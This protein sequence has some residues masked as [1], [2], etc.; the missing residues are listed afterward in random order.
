[1]CKPDEVF[2]AILADVVV[3]AVTVF[4]LVL[5]GVLCYRIIT[6]TRKRPAR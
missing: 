2:G 6:R 1:M 5:L 4:A 3:S